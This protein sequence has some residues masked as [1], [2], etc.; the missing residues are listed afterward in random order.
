[1]AQVL[2]KTLVLA[3][4]LVGAEAARSQAVDLFSGTAAVRSQNAEERTRALSPALTVALV[5]ASGDSTVAA[6]PR[7]PALLEQAPRLLRSFSYRQ[8]MAA[9]EG[10]TTTVR[11]F[12]VAQFDPEGVRSLLAELGRGVWGERPRTTVWLVVDDG[13][14][15][16][17]ANASQ[18]AAL[19]ALTAQARARGISL[20]L[21]RMDAEDAAR[22]SVASLWTGPASAALAASERYATPVAL[23]VRLARGANGWTSRC[24]LTDGSR[25]EEWSRNHPDANAAL[26]AAAD[27]LAD[28]LAQRF[29][30]AVAER[31][32]SEYRIDVSGIS[33]A[34]DF[35]R[36]L[37]Y[38]GGLSVVTSA[39]P[40]A[41]DGTTLS[42][43][44][45]LN[46]TP[47]RLRQ[48][49]TLGN[50]LVFDEGALADERR[51]AL[52]LQR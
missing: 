29:S 26:A 48:V 36:V 16:R 43:A 37:A 30:V 22:V 33:N 8:D 28:R 11:E 13:S 18:V 14:A 35:A 23:V 6:D 3:L 44:V 34:D 9:G 31:V 52:R 10:G 2:L 50:T 39:T 27:G 15:R 7:L 20:V 42:F 5:K 19:G 4:G 24:T 1:L 21:P 51:I 17:I 45:T 46:V 25:P 40:V 32:I 41:A 12:L 47:A 38:L 49:L